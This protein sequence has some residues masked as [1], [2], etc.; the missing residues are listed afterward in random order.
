MYLVE[1]EMNMKL[2]LP[3]LLFVSLLSA[4]D[5]T[6]NVTGIRGTKG[7]IIIKLYNKKSGFPKDKALY[8]KQYKKISSTTETITFTDIPSGDYA[9]LLYHDKNANRKIDTNIIGIPKE[10]HGISRNIKLFGPP[11]FDKCKFRVDEDKTISIKIN[12]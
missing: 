12:Y 2:L 4:Q 5:L 7:G 1:K 9:V 11:K 10:P 3:I 6:I 8:R